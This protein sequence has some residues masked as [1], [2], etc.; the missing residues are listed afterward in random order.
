MNNNLKEKDVFEEEKDNLDH[1]IKLIEENIIEAQKKHDENWEEI[2]SLAE[3]GFESYDR[4]EELLCNNKKLDKVLELNR[5]KIK[6]PYFGHML[7]NIDNELVDIYI[8]KDALEDINNNKIVY[9]WRAP[10]VSLYFA[11]QTSFVYEGTKVYLEF[12]RNIVIKNSQLLQCHEA[13]S[14]NRKNKEITDEFLK[15]ILDQKRNND[16]FVDIIKTIQTKQNEIIR[17]N[18][19]SNIICQGVAGSGKTVIIL[20]RISYLI[21]NNKDILPSSFLFIAPTNLFLNKLNALNKKLQIDTITTKTLFDYYLEKL[22][23][24]FKDNYSFLKISN[25]LYESPIYFLRKYSEKYYSKLLK[26]ISKEYDNDLNKYIEKYDINVKKSLKLLDKARKIEEM[27]KSHKG[28]VVSTKEKLEKEIEE[29]FRNDKIKDSLYI[30]IMESCLNHY[31]KQDEEKY[32]DESNY[33]NNIKFVEDGLNEELE[34]ITINSEYGNELKKIELLNNSI[35]K[36]YEKIYINYSGIA[37]FLEVKFEPKN[38]NNQIKKI[39]NIKYKLSSLLTEKN[40]LIENINKIKNNRF[41][42]LFNSSKIKLLEKELDNIEKKILK[43]PGTVSNY[44]RMINNINE[45][46]IMQHQKEELDLKLK[47]NKD[48]ENFMRLRNFFDAYR[49]LILKINKYRGLFKIS[50]DCKKTIIRIFKKIYASRGEYISSGIYDVTDKIRFLINS[51]DTIKWNDLQE[52]VDS[53]QEI[54]KMCMPHYLM[55]I[56]ERYILENDLNAVNNFYDINSFSINRADAYLLLRLIYDFKFKNESN[57]KYIYIDEA[58]DYNDNE[59]NLINNLEN[60]PVLNIYGDVGQQIDENVVARDNW[61]ELEKT[62]GKKFI[63]Y[64]LNENYRNTRNVVEFCNHEIGTKMMPIGND[65]KKVTEK[66]FTSLEAIIEEV[67]DNKYI[68]ICNNKDILNQLHEANIKCCDIKSS[69]GLE[70]QN[71]ILINDHLSRNLRYVA[72]TRTLNNLIVY[73]LYKKL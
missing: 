6:N 8:G 60:N 47:D 37:D 49:D 62:I 45:L 22:N 68:V 28:E 31:I 26:N 61:V 2:K 50:S 29:F 58:Q 20:H 18:V 59:I 16:E 1:N 33:K 69:K 52:L 66:V 23:Y 17:E 53:Y 54:N 24:F 14:T 57:Y 34:K 15:T 46:V 38:I 9:D 3:N 10:T 41:S 30:T 39:K 12:K 63:T 36:T 4:K 71:V 21:F 32:F 44:E 70:F 48:Y 25:D 56:Y 35:M 64:K 43:I 65:G 40:S 11:N 67:K 42:R 5:E 55:N 51:F 72:Y 7:L 13:Y 27:L 19:N 73:N